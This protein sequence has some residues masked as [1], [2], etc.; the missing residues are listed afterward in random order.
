HQGT[1]VLAEE[2]PRN[3]ASLVGPSDL[4][5]REDASRFALFREGAVRE[6]AGVLVEEAKRAG[7]VVHPEGAV[8]FLEERELHVEIGRR[9]RSRSH[10]RCRP[11]THRISSPPLSPPGRGAGG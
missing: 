4:A 11:R 7:A 1:G 9:G 10:A 6:A 8:G 5:E 2:T 3:V